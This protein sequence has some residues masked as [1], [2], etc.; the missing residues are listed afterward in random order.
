MA[1]AFFDDDQAAALSIEHMVFHLVGPRDSDL[2]R[3]QAIDPGA[4]APFFLDRIRTV[5]AGASYRFSD[6]S[7]TRER[8]RRIIEDATQF[9]EESEKLAEDFQRKHGG[10]TAAGAFLVFLLKAGEE[11]AF[12]LLKYDDETVL[13]YDVEEAADGRKRVSL[14]AM[15]RTFVQ[16]REA[17]QKS[18]L[19][20]LTEEGGDLTVLDRRN[21]QKVARYFESFLDAVR[22]HEDDDLTQKL[23]DVTRDVIKRNRD[24]VPPQV[25]RELTRLTYEAASAGGQLASDNQKA[26]LDTVVGRVLPDDDPLVAKFK[27]ALRRARIDGAPVTLDASRVTQP[28]TTRYETVN[29]VQIRVPRGAEQVIDVQQDRIIINDRVRDTYDD[30]D[31]TL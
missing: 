17:L 8:L 20:R 10:G 28:R 6:A 27:S 26:F 22:L 18:A 2:I 23:V 19:V 12:A 4:F 5:N 31:S 30:P 15:E 14:E 7:A 21:Q 9:Q 1:V 29:G 11:R 16:N 13:T 3:L 24:L 25:H